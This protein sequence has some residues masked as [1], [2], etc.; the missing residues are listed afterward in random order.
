LEI[1]GHLFHRV[2][3]RF[4]QRLLPRVLAVSELVEVL[5]LLQADDQMKQVLG[6][7]SSPLPSNRLA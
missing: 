2:A 6:S 3:R 5:F 1:G 4:A 7:R